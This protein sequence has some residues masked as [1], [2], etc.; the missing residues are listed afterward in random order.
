VSEQTNSSSSPAAGSL[1]TMV[2]SGPESITMGSANTE[3]DAVTIV[4]NEIAN[5]VRFNVCFILISLLQNP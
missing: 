5:A 2:S 4:N 3:K 1:A